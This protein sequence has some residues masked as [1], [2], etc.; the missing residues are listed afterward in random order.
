METFL[1]IGIGG[2][3]GA[4]VRYW[5][6][7]W[8]VEHLGKLFP[9]GTLIINFSGSALLGVFLAWAGNR[10]T[11]DP[12]VRLLVAVGFFGAYTT[13]STYANETV[14]LIQAGDWAGALGNVL[15]SNLLCILGALVGVA[16]G[17][18]L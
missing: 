14:T 8:A 9:W 11:L 13:F 3:I 1:L 15:G 12:R 4:N 5:V 6:G 10:S 2:F 16:I 17:S 18:L 7:G